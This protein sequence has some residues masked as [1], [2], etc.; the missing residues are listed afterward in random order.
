[1]ANSTDRPTHC[2]VSND[3]LFR[4]TPRL[5]DVVNMLFIVAAAFGSCAILAAKYI[6]E[7]GLRKEQ[8]LREAAAE[9]PP[10]SGGCW[11]SS[12][13]GTATVCL[14]R[15]SCMIPRTAPRSDLA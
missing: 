11:S 14:L 1:M 10:V 8:Y 15:E 6:Y 12:K 4:H 5:S 7:S 2:A 13:R 3:Q 9:L